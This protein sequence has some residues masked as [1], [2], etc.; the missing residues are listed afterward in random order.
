M[1]EFPVIDLMDKLARRLDA[2][3]HGVF[4]PSDPR[5]EGV[6]SV[7]EDDLVTSLCDEFVYLGRCQ[8]SPTS[9]D[10]IQ[11]DL[12]LIG[13]SKGHHFV[14]N[15]HPQSREVID[16]AVGP[17]EVDRLETG[18]IL[19]LMHVSL[20]SRHLATQRAVDAVLRDQDTTLETKSPTEC[21][22]PESNSFG[23]L[24]G[25]EP[26]VQDYF[27]EV[28]ILILSMAA[29]SE[30]RKHLA[31][32]TVGHG[33]RSTRAGESVDCY[34]MTEALPTRRFVDDWLRAW[35]EHDLDAIMEHFTEDVVFASPLA[36]QLIPSS[37]GVVRGKPALRV[38]WAEGLRRKPDLHFEL[39]GI[40][41]GVG[42]VVI[43][44]VNELGGRVCEV[45]EFTGE[46]VSRGYGTYQ[47]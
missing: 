13:C 17:L 4:K 33:T 46:L 43:N 18:V 11:V 36:A 24:Q 41:E 25:R 38:Y 39:K 6:S 40:Y 20:E 27:L 35:N 9:D 28:H 29:W 30:K 21:F 3:H 10:A 12:D 45:L 14:A 2:R 15:P 23:I 42:I 47:S 32:V 1:V 34:F 7:E 22:L 5:L 8:A 31:G 26:V 37:K 19:R 44:Y 16:G